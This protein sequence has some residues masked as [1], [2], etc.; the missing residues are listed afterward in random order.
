MVVHGQCARPAALADEVELSKSWKLTVTCSQGQ[1]CWDIPW[2]KLANAAWEA[3]VHLDIP[4]HEVTV[5]VARNW[6]GVS[7]RLQQSQEVYL[8]VKAKTRRLTLD[9]AKQRLGTFVQ[10]INVGPILGLTVEYIQIHPSELNPTHPDKG[11]STDTMLIVGVVLGVFGVL[12]VI[13]IGYYYYQGWIF[14]KTWSVQVQEV[15]EHDVKFPETPTLFTY[16]YS[17]PK[18][19]FSIPKPKTI[20]S[21]QQP[22][23]DF[24]W[25]VEEIYKAR[26]ARTDEE[27]YKAREARTDEPKKKT[28]AL[29]CICIQH[30]RWKATKK[31]ANHNAQRITK[32]Q[33]LGVHLGVTR[34]ARDAAPNHNHNQN[35][36][37]IC[38]PKKHWDE[39]CREVPGAEQL[40][41]LETYFL[42]KTD[43]GSY[44][45][46]QKTYGSKATVSETERL[47]D[48]LGKGGRR[49][50]S[51]QTQEPLFPGGCGGC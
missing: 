1:D 35:H 44:Q 5:K 7:R 10:T 51:G 43:R 41:A 13:G 40:D 48:V 38:E 23:T 37:E 28:D 31:V 17:I 14:Q 45:I 32:P 3:A 2:K 49:R 22:T 18:P 27:I 19:S 46:E 36:K 24:D 26:K 47:E 50:E 29:E 6:A 11:S 15:L 34:I 4:F 8:T 39:T 30:W 33:H 42:V 16:S 25:F 20:G 12:L 21:Q 9:E